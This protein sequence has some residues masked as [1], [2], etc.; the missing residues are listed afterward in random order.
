MM[1]MDDGDYLFITAIL[2]LVRHQANTQ[3]GTTESTIDNSTSYSSFFPYLP[4]PH[5]LCCPF[6]SLLLSSLLRPPL[7]Q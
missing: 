4:G 5:S 3:H 7:P 2:S 1:L 6:N